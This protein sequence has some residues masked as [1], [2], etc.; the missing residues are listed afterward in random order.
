MEF[1]S[2]IQGIDFK[3]LSDDEIYQILV[4]KGIYELSTPLPPPE[5][6]P[7]CSY[8]QPGEACSDGWHITQGG[9]SSYR[10]PVEEK[11]EV[12]KRIPDEKKRLAGLLAKSGYYPAHDHLS[13]SQVLLSQID[14]QRSVFGQ[15]E[16]VETVKENMEKKPS[17]NI[18]FSGSHGL[19]K[20]TAQLILHFSWLEAGFRSRFIDS[21]FLRDLFRTI[22]RATD[23]DMIKK[24]QQ[25]L[26]HLIHAQVI[27]WS[28]V[29]DTNSSYQT[30]FAESLY[31]LLEKSKA[32]WVL[33]SNLDI[34]ELQ[35]H[36]DIGERAVSRMV[37]D[38]NGFPAQIVALKGGDQRFHGLRKKKTA[39]EVK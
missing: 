14:L 36:P 10:C 7:V 38:R 17:R 1:S 22:S 32:V 28:D 6:E 39:E 4:S 18:Y 20:T 35:K 23:E 8:L 15:R 3:N 27:L 31:S 29:G 30:I 37:S 34:R 25:Q 13:V 26:N 19:A 5:K 16:L 9:N 11:K 21:I 2:K 24:E 12:Q 33:S